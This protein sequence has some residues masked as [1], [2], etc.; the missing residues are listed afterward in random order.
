MNKIPVFILFLS[1]MIIS[2]QKNRG[3]NQD[4]F[5]P[6]KDEFIACDC[7]PLGT[8]DEASREYIKFVINNVPICADLKG[9]VQDTFANMLLYGTHFNGG[10]ISYY[11]NLYMIRNTSDWRF[12]VAIFMENT[13]ALTKTYPY[14]LP[15]P[16]PEYCEIATL[17][18]TNRQK[19]TSNMCSF[20]ITND[21]HYYGPFFY[22]GLH[23]IV[24]KYENGYFEGRFSGLTKT[25][26]GRPGIIKDGSFRIK[27]TEIRRNI[28]Q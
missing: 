6:Y 2:C 25:G 1:V 24:D 17:E 4:E 15:R 8:K 14:E 26:S 23:L 3:S 22:S 19:V 21:W 16:N 12:S 13:H 9:N 7:Q 18:I 28:I 27:L 10:N 11:D 20:C 5:N